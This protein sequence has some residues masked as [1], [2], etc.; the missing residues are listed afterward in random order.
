MGPAACAVGSTAGRAQHRNCRLGA[1][2]SHGRCR[3]R[4]AAQGTIRFRD[5]AGRCDSK[6]VGDFT[7]TA[8]A[9]RRAGT[10]K[11]PPGRPQRKLQLRIHLDHPTASADRRTRHKTATC[12]G[13][14]HERANEPSEARAGKA[15]QAPNRRDEKSPGLASCCYEAIR[16]A[17]ISRRSDRGNAEGNRGNLEGRPRTPHSDPRRRRKGGVFAAHFFGIL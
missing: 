15:L 17:E 14:N 8:L 7:F 9:P 4:V 6:A 2:C 11:R 16:R 12:P 1:R 3:S 13:E 5:S 10:R